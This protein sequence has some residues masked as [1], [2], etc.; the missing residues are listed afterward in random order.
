MISVT[1]KFA[2]FAHAAPL[3]RHCNTKRN[4]RRADSM[5]TGYR[6]R[7]RAQPVSRATGD[8]VV[9]VEPTWLCVVVSTPYRPFFA[10]LVVFLATVFFPFFAPERLTFLAPAALTTSGRLACQSASKIWPNTAR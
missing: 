3:Q 4:S 2:R 10:F 5:L 8:R 9:E 7:W 6:M 1:Y